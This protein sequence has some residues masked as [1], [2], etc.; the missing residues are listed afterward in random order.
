[1]MVRNWS[2]ESQEELEKESVAGW[3]RIELI[4]KLL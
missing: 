4:V 1:M 2:K 3:D